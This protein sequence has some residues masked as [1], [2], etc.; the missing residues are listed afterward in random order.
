MPERKTKSVFI[1]PPKWYCL[2]PPSFMVPTVSYIRKENY[3]TKMLD[4]NIDFYMTL[5][6]KDYL[7]SS[8]IEAEKQLPQ[9]FDYLQKNYQKGKSQE[10]Y[11]NDFRWKL[12]R[13]NKIKKFLGEKK[14]QVTK[15]IDTLSYSIKV[16]KDKD[17]YY[18]PV[19]L[20]TAMNNIELC[21]E[22]A[23]LPYY[24]QQ[25][26]IKS[27]ENP[28]FKL[29]FDC[30]V[31]SA[32][33]NNIFTEF[34]KNN[35]SRITDLN[36]DIICISIDA[37]SQI[38]STCTL[39][40]MLKEKTNAK[41]AFLGNYYTRVTDTI[42]KYPEFF[43][44]FC[45]YVVPDELEIP[46]LPKLFDYLEGKIPIED[47]PNILYKKENIVIEN[48]Y[49]PS[50]KLSE[51]PVWDLDDFDFS[52]YPTPELV[53]PQLSSRG[54]YWGKCSFCDHYFGQ[55]IDIKPVSQF[56]D[57]LE[58]LNKK[59]GIKHFELIDECISPPYLLAM[60]KEILKRNL[61]IY[62]FNY[63]RLEEGFNEEVLSTAYKAGCRMLLWGFESA[64]EKVMKD[65]N[66]GI[67]ISKRE[68]ILRLSRKIGI[69][70]FAF[71]FFGFPTETE[72]D[73]AETIDYLKNHKD[74]ISSYGRSVF[75]L[76][77]H[78]LLTKYPEKFSITRI[79]A[80]VEE[81]SSK[82][83]FDTSIGMNENKVNEISKKCLL[84][85]AKAYN[86]PIWMYLVYR[87]IL[88]LY[89][90]KYGADKVEQMS[91]EIHSDNISDVD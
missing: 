87:E 62:F 68:E 24:P 90:C 59:Y 3:E 29:E 44:I 37:I 53:I 40:A 86:N 41:I 34:C 54:C 61:D 66:K 5:L 30:M 58:T 56:T 88:F 46:T 39:S 84:E 28:E 80:D 64:S 65:I 4:F 21:L 27:Y 77:K 47:V 79:Y 73:A 42:K 70:N 48:E 69:W 43:D 49:C 17:L 8:L 76:G 60:S 9:L 71:L 57:E 36:P 75:T 20:T 63:A 23:S 52:K 35:I 33:S 25:I 51:R 10:S 1:I 81:F 11:N 6:N 91:V 15:A 78:S 45:D 83:H 7:N 85:C 2:N 38:V 31:K 72:A 50:I 16:M 82:L 13:Y 89:I 12:L 55:K 22:A 74:I 26:Q 14:E 18:N 32:K 19:E 67:D